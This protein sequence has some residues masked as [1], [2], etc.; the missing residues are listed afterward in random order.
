MPA[1]G[2][3]QPQR[4]H[5]L[6]PKRSHA[7]PSL[8]GLSHA[9]LAAPTFEMEPQLHPLEI[10]DPVNG[11]RKKHKRNDTLGTPKGAPGALTPLGRNSRKISMAAGDLEMNG[12]PGVQPTPPNAPRGAQLQGMSRRSNHVSALDVRDGIGGLA[13]TGKQAPAGIWRPGVGKQSVV[14][15]AV[16][17]P[18]RG[19]LGKYKALP[20]LQQLG[21]PAQLQAKAQQEQQ[22]QQEEGQEGYDE[23]SEEGY[24]EGRE[25]LR[26]PVESGDLQ[27]EGQQWPD[28]ASM[29]NQVLASPYDDLDEMEAQ[30]QADFEEPPGECTGCHAMVTEDAAQGHHAMCVFWLDPDEGGPPESYELQLR[31]DPAGDWQPLEPNQVLITG[32]GCADVTVLSEEIYQHWEQGTAALRIRACNDVGKGPWSDPSESQ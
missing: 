20:G 28:G 5:G 22:E 14:V 17:G 30:G 26:G 7:I 29:G 1:M 8:S 18:G 11:K 12:A 9:P 23:G 15:Q 13:T 16:Q 24:E 32:P 6:P 10:H 19:G 27:E 21:A 2:F 3:P 4:N 31:L 25:S